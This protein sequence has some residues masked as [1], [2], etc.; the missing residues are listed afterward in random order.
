MDFVSGLPRSLRGHDTVWVVVDRL[1]KSAHFLPIRLSNSAEDL[2]VI[3]VREIVRLHGVP[4]SIVSDRDP[5]FT[6]LFWKGM[7]SAL[8]SDLRLSTAFYP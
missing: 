3:Y 4:V 6:S 7:Q 2:G 8:G 1:T 5:R